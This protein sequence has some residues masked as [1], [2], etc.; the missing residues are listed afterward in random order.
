MGTTRLCPFVL[1]ACLGFAHV[2]RVFWSCSKISGGGGNF[3]KI[4]S[5]LCIFGSLDVLRLVVLM[6]CA[7]K[8]LFGM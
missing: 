2:S 1:T 4:W 6:E 3:G 7:V 8:H 5:K